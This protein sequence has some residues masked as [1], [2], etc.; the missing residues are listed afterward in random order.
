MWTMK[1]KG[2][3]LKKKKKHECGL[4]LDLWRELYLLNDL[5]LDS[6]YKESQWIT[7]NSKSVTPWEN[8]S[9]LKYVYLRLFK[10][11]SSKK[12]DVESKMNVLPFQTHE[13][14]PWSQF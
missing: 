12:L 8:V 14:V 7:E 1:K 5:S 6:H 3:W 4:N 10:G 11:S 2:P 9:V 13:S